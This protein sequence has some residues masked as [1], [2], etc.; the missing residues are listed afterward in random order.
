MEIAQLPA[1][2]N[3]RIKNLNSYTVLDTEDEKEYNDLIELASQICDCPIALIT[4]VDNDRQWFKAK[5]NVEATQTSRDIAFCSHTILQND[6]M[7]IKDARTHKKFH[8]NP[9]V[10][11]ELQIGF[12]AG[13]PIVSSA[14]YKL[15]SVCVID[16]TKKD[17]L[18]CKQKNSLK[19]IAGQVSKLLELRAQNKKIIEQTQMQIKAEK[20][21]SQLA[22]SESDLKDNSIGYELYE[23]LAQ[24]L[25]AIKLF[26][27]TAE[28]SKDLKNKFLQK[29]K[30][31]ITN[32]I[33][34]VENLSKSIIPTTLKNADYYWIIQEYALH[35]GKSNNIDISFGETAVIKSKTSNIG[36]NMFRIVQKQLEVAH[37]SGAEF[38]II[39]I[40]CNNEISLEFTY[41][42]HKLN[43]DVTP[44]LNNIITRIE[45]INGKLSERNIFKEKAMLIKIPFNNL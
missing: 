12:Y 43:V 44:Q 30:D 15:G 40:K 21:I 4:F 25:I 17:D 31:T 23:N 39:D 26:I 14:G 41:D 33:H 2:E 28:N 36:I 5:K 7:V 8:D 42:V 29:S 24:T 37:L 11:G 22:I 34:E 6:V 3:L 38:V 9:L 45:L 10:T 35:F 18:T 1:E 19:I 20:K 27:E 16:H 13:A 32:L